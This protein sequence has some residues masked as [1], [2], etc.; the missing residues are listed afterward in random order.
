MTEPRVSG[1]MV[2]SFF[3]SLR[4]RVG[5][6]AFETVLRA[7]HFGEPAS[8]DWIPV[9]KWQ[10]LLED[11]E[12]RFGDPSTLQ[13]TR[14][15]TRSTMAVAISKGWSAFLSEATP[16]SLLAQSG[17]FWSLSY[18]AGKLVVAARGPRRVL[19]VVEEWP[20]PPAIV[21]ASVAEAIAVF[22][23]RLGEREPRAVDRVTDGRGEI[24]LTW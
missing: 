7:H 24:E 4:E 12:R 6:P 20:S 8:G 2:R 23:A 5:E 3:R 15:L 17:R 11:F 13:L 18:D 21:V 10:P 22:L 16:D 1:R 9:A 14:E 19:F